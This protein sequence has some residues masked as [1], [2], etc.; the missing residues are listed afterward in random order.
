[1]CAKAHRRIVDF[2]AGVRL[3][4]LFACT[5]TIVF[6]CA[7]AMAQGWTEVGPLPSP[8]IVATGTYTPS[9]A[10]PYF[11]GWTKPVY[12]SSDQGLLVY[13]ANPDCCDGTFSNAVFLYK[14]S[15]NSWTLLWSHMTTAAG[16]AGSPADAPDAPADN[17]PYHAMA[18]DSTRGVLWK[19][20]GSATTGGTSGNCGDC[21][22]SDTYR[23]DT[24]SSQAVWTEICGNT[25]SACPP[26]PLQE[27]TLAYDPV[28]DTLVL[29]GGLSGGS[30]TADTWEFTPSN[31]TWTQ[32]CGLSAP[33]LA[34]CG[35]PLS[36]APGLV[37][38][39][40]LGKFVLFGGQPATGAPMNTTTWLYSV[41]THS[42]T[43]VNTSTN[44]LGSKFPVMDYVPRLAAV[45]LVGSEST[46]AHTWAFNGAQWIDLNVSG[47]PVLSTTSKDNQGAYDVSADRFVLIL[48]GT[49]DGGD[50]WS[51]DLPSS[52]NVPPPNPGPAA[53][54]SQA[55]V[56]FKAQ[57][58]GTESSIQSVTITS[59]GTAAL[60]FSGITITGT[61]S[62]DFTE[63]NTCPASPSTLAVGSSCAISF[64]FKPSTTGSENALANI[65]D[66]ST[67]GSPQV[68]VLQG[69]GIAS[70][71][72]AGLSPSALNF[73]NQ[74]QGTSSAPQ[75]L[76]VKNTGN[77][78]LTVS[79]IAITGING[80]DFSQTNTCPA[81]PNTLAAG[82]NCTISVVFK[83]STAASESAAVNIS[84]NAAGSPQVVALQG[85]GVAD[86]VAVSLSPNTLNFGSQAQGTS[87]A[88]QTLTI[89]NTGNATLTINSIAITGAN[90]G[91]FSETNTCPATLL[92][93]GSCTV[94]VIFTPSTA[95][96]DSA[97]LSVSDNA[98]GSPQV[99]ALQGT[100][101]ASGP[102]ASLSPSSLN[103][104]SQV[105]G[106]ST[107][108]QT[109]T[110]KN[111]G[112][113]A[114]TISSIAITGANAG[115][116]SETNTCPASPNTLAPGGSC[117]VSVVFTPS[118]DASDSAA[119]SIS[120]NGSESTHSVL[121]SGTG[122][123][124]SFSLS[125]TPSNAIVGVGQSASYTIT[126]TPSGGSFNNAVALACSN[127]PAMASC[128]FSPNGVTPG[129]KSV[130]S[131]LTIT[132]NNSVATYFPTAS[133]KWPSGT[134]WLAVG[135]LGLL[136]LWFSSWRGSRE[137]L[138]EGLAI[139]TIVCVLAFQSGCTGI[140]AS[141]SRPGTPAGT[142][143]N[144]SV[145][146][147]SG[148]KQASTTISL[149]VQ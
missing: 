11:R 37:Y 46:G 45:V 145:T 57:A 112:N 141:S 29:Y 54:L 1:M 107:A 110:I 35:P 96:N 60:T 99:A 82:A 75:I 113:T 63:T 72:V 41:D 44:P 104:G 9:D 136:S 134:P 26:G 89:K 22:V 50:V 77:A 5:L 61:N 17:H 6:T 23:F 66:D 88:P 19:V 97:A 118:T 138:V 3:F 103:F 86:G 7:S 94:T 49:N 4:G 36:D 39:A 109:L 101:I 148:S 40:A 48:P 125:A 74:A 51:L 147:S 2:V 93:A 32:I 28:H 53:T 34:P 79:S 91:D 146:A 128:S 108:P 58:V 120:D 114:L 65:S 59:T 121:L 73:G 111:T 21:G 43:Q 100:G 132:T 142:Y 95:A 106:T 131:T 15:A 85:A 80:G 38:D 87:S 16:T 64:A 129:V 71:P 144:I 137:R 12:D 62:G 84:D 30:P 116:F 25:M 139:I 20:F 8:P 67:T 81:S 69:V 76:T 115:D 70:G 78:A 122:V 52:L 31:N 130:S 83:P 92:A 98:T 105:Q 133:E 135:F 149:T 119:V 90:A 24:T 55:T 127:L 10:E 47:G 14:E 102:A 56:S 13:F 117:T 123:A 33:P 140:T 124:P 27:T 42:W 18:W 143:T 126:I 68:I